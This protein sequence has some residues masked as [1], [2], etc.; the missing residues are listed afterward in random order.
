MIISGGLSGGSGAS[1][2]AYATHLLNVMHILGYGQSTSIGV[3]GASGGYL[4]TGLYGSLMFDTGLRVNSVDGGGVP[5]SI[6]PLVE[7]VGSSGY[8]E[9]GIASACNKFRASMAALG[10]PATGDTGLAMFGSTG[11]RGGMSAA[12]L[13]KGGAYYTE[14][15]AMVTNAL[16]L[17]AAAGKSYGVAAMPYTHGE[18]DIAN[19]TGRATYKTLV[20]AIA[21]NFLADAVALTKQDYPPPFVMAQVASQMHYYDADNSVGFRPE[22]ALGQR[23]LAAENDAIFCAFPRYIFP[24]FDNVHHNALGYEAVG[25]YFGRAIAQIWD[26]RRKGVARPTIALD[27][28]S[29][30]WQGNLIDLQFNVPVA[31]LAFDAITT[32][33]ATNQGFD[34]WAADG[35]TL[36]DTIAGV[37]IAGPDRVLVTLSATPPAGARLSYGF[38]RPGVTTTSGPAT[39]ARGNLRDNAGASESYVD[40]SGATR[41]LDNFC[42]VFE[43]I[44]P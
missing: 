31:P 44:R 37:A 18:A 17:C 36:I 23:E 3:G 9:T 27:L 20:K 33:T 41:R 25:R 7:T 34:L 30:V 14:M 40:P 28:K 32:T 16:T 4:T 6:V 2:A 15:L 43:T 1:M 35:S 10:G 39:G 8:G 42:L 13:S 21:A 11:G 22:I 29:A 5:S 38:G 24:Y 26:A 19:K 12:Q